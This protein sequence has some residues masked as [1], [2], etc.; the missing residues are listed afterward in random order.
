MLR[1]A[2]VCI[3]R[4]YMPCFAGHVFAYCRGYNIITPEIRALGAAL[5]APNARILHTFALAL[6]SA[7]VCFKAYLGAA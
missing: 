2:Q 5:A 1:K 4:E 6:A 3:L 7:N